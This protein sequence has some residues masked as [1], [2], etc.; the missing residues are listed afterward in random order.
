MW[1]LA[2]A[3]LFLEAGYFALNRLGDLQRSAVEYIAITLAMSL[4][5]IFAC[6]WV[7]R[8]ACASVWL[9]VLGGLAFRLT[10]AWLYPTLTEDPH[11]YRWEGKLQ[12]AGGNPYTERPESPRWMH[13]RDGTWLRVNRK[14]LPTAYGPLL[15]WCYRLTYRVAPAEV[16]AFKVPFQLGD[17]A[18]AALVALWRPAALVV[19]FWSPLVVVEFWASGHNDSWLVFFL[20]GAVWAA[21]A[22]RWGLAY[23]A[24]WM[25]T[26]V[27][28]WPVLLFPLFWRHGRRA[29]LALAWA[30]VAALVS[31]PYWAG[32]G[33]LRGMLAGF[34]GGWTNNASLF[35]LVYAAAGK[36]YEKAKPMV[37][38]LVLVGVA[39]VVWRSREL[40]AGVRRVIVTL[41]AW[42]ANCFP[43]Y[44]TWFLPFRPPAALLLWT[45]LAPLSYHILIGY[46][47]TREWKETPLFLWLEYV[48]VYAMLLAGL[49]GRKSRPAA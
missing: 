34:L 28:F 26:L 22:R 3:G 36:D 48:P 4:F 43:W 9:V 19:Y 8:K 37:A 39:L 13:L 44:L 27:K 38:V 14:D 12:A 49:W 41:L 18:T 33:N 24:L 30:P 15:E 32:F 47:V 29:R 25:A 10:V 42:S 20:V 40:E 31:W 46:G 11:R 45:A 5:Y 6:W 23:G 7:E 2:A 21:Q 16:R 35:H 17:L 1:L